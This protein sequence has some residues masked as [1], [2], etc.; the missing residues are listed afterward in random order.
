MSLNNLRTEQLTI[1]GIIDGLLNFTPTIV[2]NND[3]EQKRKSVENINASAS[4]AGTSANS[5]SQVKKGRSRPPKITVSPVSPLPS[6]SKQKPSL[7][8]IV[9]CLKRLN[10]QNNKTFEPC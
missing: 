9:D 1:D 5:Q 8:S 10:D 4:P 6:V 3:L 7:D 2:I